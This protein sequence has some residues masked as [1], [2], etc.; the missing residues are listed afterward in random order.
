MNSATR[1]LLLLG[2]GAAAPPPLPCR[3]AAGRLRL[4]GPHLC[5]L[6]GLIQSSPQQA[7]PYVD[8]NAVSPPR[9]CCGG[10][11]GGR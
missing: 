1:L 2:K 3:D 4:P 8:V 5:C 11:G 7:T 10:G 6:F 9:R